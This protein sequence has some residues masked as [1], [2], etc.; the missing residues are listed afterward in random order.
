M[1][2][3]VVLSLLLLLW[4]GLDCDFWQEASSVNF[5]SVSFK[6]AHETLELQQLKLPEWWSTCGP[7]EQLF[8]RLGRWFC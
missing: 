4:L 6:C 7:E 2:V 3:L 8:E 1:V 5:S